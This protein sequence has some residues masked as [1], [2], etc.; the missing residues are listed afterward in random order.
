[1]VREN[2]PPAFSNYFKQC[3]DI[4]PSKGWRGRNAD[5]REKEKW[6]RGRGGLIPQNDGLEPPVVGR[7][8]PVVYLVVTVCGR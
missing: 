7:I 4:V 6:G 2:L 5:G 8:F 3:Q 1:M